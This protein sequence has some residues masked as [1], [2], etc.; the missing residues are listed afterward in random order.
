MDKM[1]LLSLLLVSL[2]EALLVT[3]LGFQLAGLRTI[4]LHLIIISIGQTISSFFIRLTNIP[5][6]LHSLV[7]IAIYVLILRI[8]TGLSLRRVT[9]IALLGLV[10]YATLETTILPSLLSIT[11]YSLPDIFDRDDIRIG[12]FLPEAAL[13]VI[14]IMACRR[15]NFRLLDFTSELEDQ[16]SVNSIGERTQKAYLFV[17]VHTC[18]AARIIAG[19]F[20]HDAIYLPNWRLSKYIFP[21]VYSLLKLN[22]NYDNNTIHGHLEKNIHLKRKR[23]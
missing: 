9:V 10:V 11:G 16:A 18:A 14:F 15:Y 2:P 17:L 12:V 7:Q 23:I 19:R 6:G 13:I 8:V 4:P 1:S 3:M 20:K 5:F 22:P 21:S